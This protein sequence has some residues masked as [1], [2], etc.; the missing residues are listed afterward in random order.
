MSLCH[1]VRLCVLG[2]GGQWRCGGV[3]GTMIDFWLYSPFL[4]NWK[5]LLLVLFI[6]CAWHL[7]AAVVTEN[8]ERN[9]INREILRDSLIRLIG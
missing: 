8:G 1:C 2:G 6:S 5:G 7:V 4:V 9:E 3:G